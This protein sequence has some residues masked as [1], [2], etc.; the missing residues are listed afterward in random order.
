MLDLAGADAE[1]ERAER[2]VRAGV[3]ITTDHGHAGQR[4]ALLRA[5][6]VHDA[7]ALVEEREVRGGAELP[8]VGVE[9][10]HLL[11]GHRIGDAVVAAL[12]AGGRRV[13]IGRG[14]D[15]ADPP[16]RTA[17]DAQAL[18]CLRTG[19]FVHQVA[20]DVKH[21]GA[22][23]LDVDHVVV[24]QLVVQGASRHE[25]GRARAGGDQRPAAGAQSDGLCHPTAST[26]PRGCDFASGTRVRNAS[27][28]SGV[29]GSPATLRIAPAR[30]LRWT[31]RTTAPPWHVATSWPDSPARR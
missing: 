26:L 30:R 16:R 25:S 24:P 31:D 15:R 22:V 13:V 7:L 17:R 2:A 4:R 5:H 11:L 20:V 14:H 28:K 12:P 19:D 3:R 18:E 27:V 1:G 6:H 9:R 23:V 10:D 21:R 29:S 8:D